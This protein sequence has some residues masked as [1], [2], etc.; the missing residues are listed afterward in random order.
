MAELTVD[1]LL[2]D[3]TFQRKLKSAVSEAKNTGEK[4][5]KGMTKP[6]ESSFNQIAN[7]AKGFVVGNVLLQL[8]QLLT[9]A[10]T[11]T[12]QAAIKQEE[13]VNQLNAAL[14]RTG[15]VSLSSSVDLQRFA[16]ELQ[17]QSVVGDEVILGQIA[18]AKSLGLTNQQTKEFVTAALNASAALGKDFGG[19]LQQLLKT[20]SGLQGE[21]GE[22]VSAIRNL[23]AEQLKAGEAAKV[24]NRQF[25]GAFISQTNTTLGSLSQLSNSLGDFTEKLG[26]SIIQSDLAKSAIRELTL[27]FD[28]LNL[29]LS[30]DTADSLKAA[31]IEYSKLK[32]E[33][34]QLQAELDKAKDPVGIRVLREKL[35]FVNDDLQKAIAKVKGFQAEIAKETPVADIAR[36]RILSEKEVEDAKNQFKLLG[37]TQIQQI[38]LVEQEQ[39]AA[40]ERARLYNND[41]ILSEQEYQNRRVEIQR[42]ASEQIK[43]LV[44][45]E[46]DSTVPLLNNIQQSFIDA[47]LA[48]Q[49]GLA[50]SVGSAFAAFGRALASGE[51]A[52]KAFVD[53]FLASIGQVAIQ[54]GTSFILQ[55]IGYQFVPGLQGTGTALIGAGAALA[56]FGGALTAIGGGSGGSP[57]AGGGT[58]FAPNEFQPSQDLR[59]DLVTEERLEPETRVAINIQGDVLDSEE[60]GLRIAKI[61]EEASLTQNVRVVGGLA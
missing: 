55:G 42:Q 35:S 16:S 11:A 57:A 34:I 1:L 20:L 47:A 25:A 3:K 12:T 51:N 8:P 58:G 5:G 48:A 13:A 41:R 17:R 29:K 37:L 2:E 23:T 50:S 49:R 10:F 46:Q 38:Q 24:F 54:Q 45:S 4:I 40:L 6:V 27:A 33:Q 22:S 61:L 15:D 60:S 30:K 14:R 53:A 56:T 32:V 39:L 9:R 44:K 26:D 7:I 28:R 36:P 21:I 52:L 19:T 18:Y 43:A 31:R 59:S